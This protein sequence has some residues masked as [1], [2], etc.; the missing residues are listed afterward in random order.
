VR[1]AFATI[2]MLVHIGDHVAVGLLPMVSK[3]E[4]RIEIGCGLGL[5]C[6]RHPSLQAGTRRNI[7]D[8]IDS[9]DQGFCTYADAIDQTSESIERESAAYED[10]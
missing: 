10:E 6:N 5:Q 4:I 7:A 2:R 8:R 1:Y 9:A 3:N